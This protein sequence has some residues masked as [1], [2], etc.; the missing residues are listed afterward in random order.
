[1]LERL[2]RIFWPAGPWTG[3]SLCPVTSWSPGVSL[4]DHSGICSSSPLGLLFLVSP[5]FSSYL[6]YRPF[7]VARYAPV[8]SQKRVLGGKSFENL[9]V[10]EY[11]YFTLTLGFQLGWIE[12][13]EADI[14]FPQNFLPSS[15]I[16][17]MEA[18]SIPNFLYVI[19]CFPWGLVGSSLGA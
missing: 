4:L 15:V 7:N 19:C 5:I 6:T 18:T 1:M 13:S 17:E 8:I 14:I 9:H 11:L 2:L 10:Y 12:N 3:C 16:E